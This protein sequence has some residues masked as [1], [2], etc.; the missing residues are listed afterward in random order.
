[1][2]LSHIEYF[3]W[4]LRVRWSRTQFLSVTSLFWGNGC[5]SRGTW[6]QQTLVTISGPH[7]YGPRYVSFIHRNE[8]EYFILFAN[9]QERNIWEEKG[10]PVVEYHWIPGESVRLNYFYVRLKI[11]VRWTIY[12]MLIRSGINTSD[13]SNTLHV[14]EHVAIPQVNTRVVFSHHTRILD[15]ELTELI[16]T[17]IT[18][19]YTRCKL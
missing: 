17:E 13:Y 11:T 6:C 16:Y 14:L 18:R 2:I 12:Q 3:I 15:F 9:L 8:L 4:L 5:H 7:V 1:M 19:I 10:P